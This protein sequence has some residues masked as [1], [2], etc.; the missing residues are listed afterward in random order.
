MGSGF[1]CFD[2]LLFRK[3]FKPGF[4][5]YLLKPAFAWVKDGGTEG[6]GDPQEIQGKATLGSERKK[7]SLIIFQNFFLG[8]RANVMMFLCCQDEDHQICHRKKNQTG[9][10]G[11]LEF[12]MN[13]T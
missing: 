2:C 9:Q 5:Q 3:V 10:L 1:V 8:R 7:F 6:A 11:R 12:Q 4:L 13:S